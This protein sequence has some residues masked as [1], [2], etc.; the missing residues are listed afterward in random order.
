MEEGRLLQITH[1]NRQ[2]GS[3]HCTRFVSMLDALSACNVRV[4][5]VR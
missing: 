1:W 3:R 2:A 5:C 4:S